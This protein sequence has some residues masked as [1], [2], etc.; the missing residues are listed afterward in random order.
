MDNKK[1]SPAEEKSIRK[2]LSMVFLSKKERRS[3][4]VLLII[5]LLGWGP[6]ELIASKAILVAGVP[7]LWL[8]WI[9]WWVLWVFAMYRLI[10][11]CGQTEFE[12]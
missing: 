8:W 2:K 11:K 12:D 10:F 5:L 4:I 9:C 3:I 7:L 6:G 1:Y